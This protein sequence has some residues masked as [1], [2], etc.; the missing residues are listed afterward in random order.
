MKKSLIALAVAG[1]LTA[2]MIAQADATLYGI[3]EMRGVDA[4]GADFDVNMNKTRL[5]VKGAVELENLDGVQGIYQFEWEFDGNGDALSST[6]SGSSVAVRKSNVG[7]KGDFGQVLF[8]RQ[9]NPA[10]ATHVTDAFKQG[11]GYAVRSNDRYANTT[12]YATP[13]MSGFVGYVAA[14][15]DAGTTAGEDVDAT[16]FGANYSAN[17]LYVGAGVTTVDG[18]AGS[19][20]DIV[21]LGA[22]YA[23][24]GL[25]GGVY[26]ANTDSGTAATD[27]DSLGVIV[28]YSANNFV[29]KAGLDQKDLTA[30]TEGEKT[31]VHAGY[32]L[33]SKA[34]AYVQINEYNDEAEAAGKADD[35]TF[36]YS[37]S[38]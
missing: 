5:G 6:N 4:D 28:A 3:A 33:G 15:T 19:D 30:S 10:A 14:V 2:P 9:N 35:F 22:S 7:L 13:N 29:L 31:T 38:F 37:L 24:D 21:E 27:L 25:S 20:T 11:S 17:G 1:A 34:Y 8:G 16:T 18:G 36:G 12:S 23:M 26:Y 32:K